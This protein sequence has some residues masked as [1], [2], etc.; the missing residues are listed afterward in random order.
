MAFLAMVSMSSW[1]KASSS[2]AGRSARARA[3][4]SATGRLDERRLAA[5]TAHSLDCGRI[6]GVGADKRYSS[7]LARKTRR[8][9][10]F[11]RRGPRVLQEHLAE[12]LAGIALLLRGPSQQRGEPDETALYCGARQQLLRYIASR[13]SRHRRHVG[14]QQQE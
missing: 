8:I 1:G 3:A 5:L 7:M 10:A 6:Y 11:L 4:L 14:P 13:G 2:I 12:H 9:R